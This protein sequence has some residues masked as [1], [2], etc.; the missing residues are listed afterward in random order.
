[1]TP[2]DDLLRLGP[3]GKATKGGGNPR[4]S[5]SELPLKSRRMPM[6]RNASAVLEDQKWQ[7]WMPED[8]GKVKRVE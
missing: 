3:E 5:S 2:R 6:T 8:D 7:V 4:L 1:M